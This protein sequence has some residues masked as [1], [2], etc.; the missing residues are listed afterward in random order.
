MILV[1]ALCFVSCLSSIVYF[2]TCPDKNTAANRVAL[3]DTRLLNNLEYYLPDN[4]LV[5]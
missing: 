3:C 1:L 4:H 2:K 5:V